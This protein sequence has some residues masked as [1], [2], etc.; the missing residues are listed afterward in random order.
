[1]NK[2]T[3]NSS[4][5]YALEVDLEY[6]V[7]LHEL[8]NNYPL[9]SDK[10]EIKR[11]FLSEYQQK[12]ADLCNISIAKVK[13]VVLNLFDKEKYVIDYENLKFFLPHF[14]S[15]WFFLNNSKAIKAVI[16]VFCIIAKLFIICLVSLTRP[17]LQILSKI[18]MVVFPIFGFLVNPL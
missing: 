10:T 7:E 14:L 1:M 3:S 8:H 13:K 9:A 12:I 5:G 16:L 4:K 2:Y 15:C 6:S 17:T 18:Q 11:K